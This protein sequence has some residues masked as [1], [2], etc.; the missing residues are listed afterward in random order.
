MKIVLSIICIFLITITLCLIIGCS[1]ATTFDSNTRSVLYLNGSSGSTTIVDEMGSI[2]P[3]SASGI[4]NISTATKLFG[5]G[6]LLNSNSGGSTGYI[7]TTNGT[8]ANFGTG[9]FTIEASIYPIAIRTGAYSMIMC[10]PT[11]TESPSFMLYDNTGG[12]VSGR[13]NFYDGTTRGGST[14]LSFNRWWNVSVVRESG[15]L[16]LYVE[17]IS[18]GS[19]ADS[20]SI[21]FGAAYIGHDST[22]SLNDFRGFIDNVRV[23]NNARYTGNYQVTNAEWGTPG[24]AGPESNSTI[25]L[26]PKPKTVIVGSKYNVT[27]FV[28]NMSGSKAIISNVY[29]NKTSINVTNVFLNSTTIPGGNLVAT[30]DP[31]NGQVLVNV[32][33]SSGYSISTLSPIAGENLKKGQSVYI[34]G[35][36]LERP[37]VKLANN[38][39]SAKCRVVGIM[40]SDLDI[41]NT[42]LVR[43]AGVLT[44]VDTRS[45]NSYTNPFG[46]TWI[47]GDLLFSTINGGMTKNRPTEG[48]SVKAAYSLLGSS[49]S[50]ILLAYPFENPVWETAALNEDIVLRT[51]D[52]TG[53]NKV[54]IRNYSN[55][56]VAYI[57]SLG[58]ASFNGI[59]ANGVNITNVQDPIG[60]KD[61]VNKEYV[62]NKQICGATY[63][64]FV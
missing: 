51:G 45:T 60:N 21:N 44:A 62:D 6:S 1:Q 22:T 48:R 54:S 17:G 59:N 16:T 29:Y 47:A 32:S 36:T 23:S 35:A 8:Y 9:D 4:A 53:T 56:E 25:S 43:R 28:N 63:A 52:S 3:W 41:N 31:A 39:D 24:G 42:G 19:F 11:G 61:A 55:S 49:S 37:I 34:S 20:N 12:G 5:S 30:L 46:E 14:Q 18:N 40:T 15:N 13:L 7:K 27:L 26:L 2:M 33:N 38:T 57:N 64:T 10:E 50:D 58:N